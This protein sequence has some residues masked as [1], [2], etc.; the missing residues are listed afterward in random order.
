[1]YIK[2]LVHLSLTAASDAFQGRCA[3]PRHAPPK[4]SAVISAAVVSVLAFLASD[5][6]A[7]P[8]TATLPTQ[9]I[10]VA[11]LERPVEILVDRWGVPH[12][13]A[14]TAQDAFFAQGF[15][16][17]R[18]R[19]F[20]IDLWRRRGLGQLAEV[21]GSSFVEQDKATRLFLYRGDMDREW[22]AYSSKG[23]RETERIAASFT[24]GINAYIDYVSVNPD[25]LPWEFRRLGYSPAKWKPEDVVRIRSHGLTRNLTSEVAR[26]NT[27]CKAGLKYDDVRVGLL[28]VW[29]TQVPE[30]LDPCLPKDVLKVFTLATQ[31]VVVAKPPATA[32][33]DAP[34]QI[35]T[36]TPDETEGSN[37]W[38]VA[39]AKS[40]TGRAIMANDPHRAYPVPSLR[41]LAHISAPGLNVIGA[42]EP[43]QPGVSLGHN[44][45]IAFGLTIFPIDQEDLYV[46]E[47]NPEN[48][49]E[50]KYQSKWEPFRTFR[51]EIRV[52]DS[53]PITADLTFTRHGPVIFIEREKLRAYAVRTAWLEPGMAPYFA[54]LDFLRARSFDRFRRSLSRWG[55]PTLN[56]VYADRQGNIGWVASGLAPRRPTWDG[57]LPVPGDGRYEWAG[58]WR[59]EDLPSAYNPK[60]G[61]FATANQLNLP[62][63]FP[64]EERRLGFEWANDSR[65]RRVA[66]V[67]AGLKKVS[68]A[69]S[70]R[71]Q[72]DLLSIPARRAAALLAPLS[73][74]DVQARAALE[75]FRDWDGVE[76][77]EGAQAALF[78]VWVTRHLG[79]A[80]REAVLPKP[81]AESISSTDLAVLLDGLENPGKW[82]G[83]DAANA[84]FRRNELMLS[85][86][87][88]AYAEMEKLQGS[89][90]S[91]WQWG[92]LHRN[93]L[94]HAFSAAVE[95]GERSRINVGPLPKGGG[96]H[97]PNQSSYRVTDFRQS[98]GPSVRLVIDVGKWDDSRAV[99]HP[100]Q[101]GDP[102]SP[103]YRD[104]AS[105]WLNGDTF[106]LLYSRG[107][108]ERA[109][110][111]RLRLV[112]IRP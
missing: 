100:G 78:E 54:S 67:L 38:V 65:Y 6:L 8:R 14:R 1:M 53:A 72:S 39:P 9:T 75:I 55:A 95:E 96:P 56:Y 40:A 35:A 61:F 52:K 76:R 102:E 26:A 70:V 107:A 92:K 17:A 25:R 4:R 108:I 71:L 24:A 12:I 47:L 74:S 58:F 105:S 83:A 68:L 66:E 3:A 33:M 7:R 10:G 101:S 87:A 5:A 98:N 15:N 64:Y 110:E 30:A 43:V 99:N 77:A 109:T 63:G 80:F 23:Q 46:Y 42:G 44:G 82:F 59:G 94:Q 18:D 11:G 13:F 29:H 36:A 103:H 48:L 73:S 89:D 28:P 104:L 45:S 69:D 79:K 84:T 81:A 2:G 91:A 85:S 86:L 88:A 37:N 22:R 21:F 60:A 19:L 106:P 41:Y 90:A 111:L 20:Q 112:P 34:L 57:L 16:A 51:E 93:F 32:G 62:A 31:E 27:A 49:S 50:Y 97:T